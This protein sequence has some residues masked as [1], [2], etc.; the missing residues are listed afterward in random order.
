ML[1]IVKLLFLAAL[2]ALGIVLLPQGWV[3]EVKNAFA[4]ARSYL[5]QTI[6]ERTP[7]V[8]ENIA[9]QTE[10]TKKEAQTIYEEFKQEKW[11][12]IKDWLVKKFIY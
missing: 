2:V 6:R 5:S 12:Q 10:E 3:D 9:S 1:G 4:D 8:K 11:P 7:E